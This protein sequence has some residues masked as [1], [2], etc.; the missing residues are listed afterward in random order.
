[1]IVVVVLLTLLCVVLCWL[2]FKSVTKNMQLMDRLESIAEEVEICLDALDEQYQKIDRASKT[3]L[4]SDEPPVK[5]L[6][7]D[8]A[9]AK[10]AVR[11]VAARLYKSLDEDEDDDNVSDEEE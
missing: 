2:L 10:E 5:E 8:M 4:F 11:A 9:A 3:D 7:R 6:V 1:M